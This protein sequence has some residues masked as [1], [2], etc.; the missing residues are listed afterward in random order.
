LAFDPSF[1]LLVIHGRSDLVTP[2][3]VSRYVLDQLPPDVSGRAQL[4]VH[5][6][7]HMLYFDDRARKAMTEDAKAFY[8]RT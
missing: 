1:R 7:G 2:Y 8:R 4:K 3:G 6:G 5:R